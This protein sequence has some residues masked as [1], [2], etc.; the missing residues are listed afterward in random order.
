M[1]LMRPPEITAVSFL[2]VVYGTKMSPVFLTL[3]IERRPGPISH[4]TLQS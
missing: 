3:L 2:S 1:H 4:I